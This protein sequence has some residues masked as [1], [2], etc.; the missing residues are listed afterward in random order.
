MSSLRASHFGLAVS[1]V[2]RSER[3][4]CNVLGFTVGEAYDIDEGLDGIM[5]LSEVRVHS[6]FLR[7]PDI[8]IELL[9]YRSP[10]A[11]GARERRPMNQ[12][13]LTHMSFWVADLDQAIAKVPQFGGVVHMHTRALIYGNTLIYCSDPDGIRIEL[14]QPPASK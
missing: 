11:F 14:M 10:P 6:R 12:Y 2:D 4:Y 7:R 3:F 1:D 5:E 8:S 13:G 9:F